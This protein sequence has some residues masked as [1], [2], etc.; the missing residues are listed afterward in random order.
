MT[1]GNVPS[2][3]G[4]YFLPNNLTL[5]QAIKASQ[6]ALPSDSKSIGMLYRPALLAQANVRFL[7]RNY[8][9][10]YELQPTALVLEPDR[11]GGVRWEE[12][13]NDPIE[14]NSLD[15]R[16]LADARYH[17]LEAPFSDSKALR[18]M[19]SDF[20]DWIYYEHK[21]TVMA[22]EALK[23]YA[24]PQ[25]PQTEFMQMCSEAA[26]E[27]R[28]EEIEKTEQSLAKKIDTLKDRLQREERELREDET[29]LSQ[30]K[31]EE[32]GT[33]AENVLGLFT[34]R[35]R[36]ITTSLSKRRMTSSA[37]ADVEE[38]LDTIEKYKRD[39]EALGKERDAAI[40]EIKQRWDSVAEDVSEIPVTPYKKDIL[41]K[42]FGIAWFPYH[43]V[44]SD[45]RTLELPAYGNP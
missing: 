43:L 24:G 10:D 21:V 14:I 19:E 33:H 39:I 3:V 4:E 40:E 8:N 44:E 27:K 34:G 18:T 42:L 15:R 35:R 41:I 9:L 32:L 2:G 45:G 1:R 7:K 37:K 11:L 12:W 13:G 26:N 30:R 29:E 16:P 6:Q 17:P 28:D 20:I 5:S 36:K 31:L 23:I 25:I 38:S 22:N